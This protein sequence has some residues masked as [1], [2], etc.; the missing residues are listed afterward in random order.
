[1]YVFGE[2]LALALGYFVRDWHTINRCV[3]VYSIGIVILINFFLPESPRLILKKKNFKIYKL[4]NYYYFFKLIYLKKQKKRVLVA[5]KKYTE[6][7]EVLVKIAS[8][9]GKQEALMPEQSFID[10]LSLNEKI[11]PKEEEE[12]E[13]KEGDVEK[14]RIEKNKEEKTQTVWEYLMNPIYNL[15]KTLL[16]MYIW[17]ALA[18]IY[19]GESL[20]DFLSNFIYFNYYF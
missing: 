18:M 2:L 15:I 7:Y 4:R 6:A 5:N 3:G 19:Y 20:G 14:I 10:Y 11:G 16:L 17:I 1:M 13:E 9:N 8:I 12:D